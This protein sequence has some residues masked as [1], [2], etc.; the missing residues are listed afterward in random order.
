MKTVEFAFESSSSVKIA[1]DFNSW[2]PQDME[3]SSESWKFLIDL[4]EGKYEYKY[5]IDGQWVVDENSDKTEKDGITN[6][7]IEVTK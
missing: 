5:F 3:K 2:E 7:L 4:P 1:G 6:N